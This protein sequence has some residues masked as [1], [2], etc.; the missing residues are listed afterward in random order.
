MQFK[1]DLRIIWSH[2]IAEPHLLIHVIRPVQLLATRVIKTSLQFCTVP[3]VSDILTYFQSLKYLSRS[4]RP[5]S[6]VM[7][8]R[9]TSD[10][11]VA[12][13]TDSCYGIRQV[14]PSAERPL[15]EGKEINLEYAAIVCSLLHLAD[16]Q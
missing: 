9:T 15:S 1:V 11:S 10:A 3:S 14:Y 7:S 12:R 4:W 16:I 6:D 13:Y 5:E 2:V 8:I